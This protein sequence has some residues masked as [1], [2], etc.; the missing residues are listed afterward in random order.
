M[1]ICVY[2][3]IYICIYVRTII[4]KSIIIVT[5][6]SMMIVISEASRFEPHHLDRL[7]SPGQHAE[8][9]AARTDASEYMT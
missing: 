3:Y 5:F 6:I 7:N 9:F 1:R 8:Q 2:I 4:I